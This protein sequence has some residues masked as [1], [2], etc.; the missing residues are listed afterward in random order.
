MRRAALF[1]LLAC[2][3]RRRP[4]AGAARAGGAR[5]RQGAGRRLGIVQRRPRPQMHRHLQHRYRAGRFQAR[6]RSTAAPRCSRCSRTWRSGASC[7]TARCACSTPRAMPRLEMSEVESG[8][9]EGERRGEGLYFMQ[10]Q[11]AATIPVRT[12]EQMFGDWNFLREI[13]KPLCSADAVARARH[14]H[15]FQAD[16]EA[17]LRRRDREFR[18]LDLAARGRPAG[19]HRPRRLLA[20]RGER[21]QHLGAHPAQHQSAADAQ[22]LSVFPAQRYPAPPDFGI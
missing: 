4:R 20:I 7:R 1:T 19:V 15:G 14:R 18:A 22:A 16:G 8:I 13:D 9:F 3:A 2:C 21:Y 11:G 12:P 5:C 17:G 6:A 10:P